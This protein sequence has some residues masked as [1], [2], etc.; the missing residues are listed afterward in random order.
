MSNNIQYDDV[1]LDNLGSC[2]ECGQDNILDG[3]IRICFDCWCVLDLKAQEA[4]ENEEE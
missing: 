3:S 4:K 1:E 2:K